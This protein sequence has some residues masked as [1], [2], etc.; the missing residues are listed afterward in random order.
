MSLDELIDRTPSYAKDLKL[1]YSSLVRQQSELSPQQLWG[2]VIASAMASRNPELTRAA[3]TDAASHLSPQA[4]D[5]A[6]SA[7][8]IMGMNNTYYRFTHLIQN[9]KYKTIPAR[10]RMNSIRSHGIEQA[11]FEL[12][13]IAVSAVNGCGACMDSHE[14]VVREKG[15]AEE[16]IAAAVRIASVIHALACVIDAER[17]VQSQSAAA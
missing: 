10:L 12:W 16:K 4:L 8:A 15:L 2:T 1:N 11:D 9:E 6:K 5:A 17:A 13:C 14:R 7:A 3:L